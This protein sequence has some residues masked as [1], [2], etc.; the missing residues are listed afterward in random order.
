MMITHDVSWGRSRMSEANR[1]KG[2]SQS[3]ELESEGVIFFMLLELSRKCSDIGI[4]SQGL[5]FSEFG[6]KV[7]DE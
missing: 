4:G 7:A 1:L 3:R 2:W 6:V 5:I